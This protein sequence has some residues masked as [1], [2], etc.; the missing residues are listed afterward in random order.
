MPFLA[1]RYGA[2]AW[3]LLLTVG[4]C[5]RG[6]VV[7]RWCLPAINSW[8]D[9]SPFMHPGRSRDGAASLPV[10]LVPAPLLPLPPQPRGTGPLSSLDRS[11]ALLRLLEVLWARCFTMLACKHN[12]LDNH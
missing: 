9:R 6:S 2:G 11:E 1:G 4:C 7:N 8:A 5:R 3:K 12:R 10:L